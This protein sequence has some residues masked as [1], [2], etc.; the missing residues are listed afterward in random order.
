MISIDEKDKRI[1]ELLS[2]DSKLSFRKISKILNMSITSVITRIRKLEENGIIRGY[3]IEIDYNKLGYDL[4]VIIDIRVAKGKLFEVEKEVA[5]HPNVLAVYDI[6][7]DFDVSVLA[8]FKNRR[9]LDDFVKQLQKMEYV[10]RT[11]TKLILNT[12]KDT[13]KIKLTYS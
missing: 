1:L 2:S 11:Y 9:E 3:T 5:K 6:T 13:K 12:I 8:L 10:E 4:P 7:G